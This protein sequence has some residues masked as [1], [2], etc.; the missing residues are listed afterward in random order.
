[1]FHTVDVENQIADVAK[2]GPLASYRKRA[3]FNWK[4]LALFF[5]DIDLINYRVLIE[6]TGF[7]RIDYSIFRLD[8]RKEYGK[9]YAPILCSH[10]RAM[11]RL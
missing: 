4:Q 3:T 2:S 10:K 5:D 11:T 9:H 1:M 6:A 8:L 7:C